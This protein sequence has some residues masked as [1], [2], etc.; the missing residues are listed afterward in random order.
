M[1]V[2]TTPSA[3]LQWHLRMLPELLP[4][5][6]PPPCSQYMM[7]MQMARGTRQ[8]CAQCFK[9][10]RTILEPQDTTTSTDMDW[11]TRKKVRQESRQTH[12]SFGLKF[13]HNQK[14]PVGAFWFSCRRSCSRIVTKNS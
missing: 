8:K 4:W 2:S 11:L 5:C 1:T 7:L 9:R 12:K 6:S 13:I 3:E 10:L 14:A